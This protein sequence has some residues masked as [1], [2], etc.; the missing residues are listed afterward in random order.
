LGDDFSATGY[1]NGCLVFST[2]AINAKDFALNSEMA[3][4]FM[5][6]SWSSEVVS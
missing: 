4:S 5:I 2:R 6:K 3:I 1:Q